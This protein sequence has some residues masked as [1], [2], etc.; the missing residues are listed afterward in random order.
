MEVF[1]DE[2]WLTNAGRVGCC[3]DGRVVDRS[4]NAQLVGARA[5][6][7]RRPV[8]PDCVAQPNQS[9]RGACKPFE[10]RY[11]T[12]AGDRLGAVLQPVALLSSAKVD[13]ALVVLFEH[14]ARARRGRPLSTKPIWT[15]G[16]AYRYALCSIRSFSSKHATSSTARAYSLTNKFGKRS[17]WHL[18]YWLGTRTDAPNRAAA[19]H[20]HLAS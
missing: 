19:C 9:A 13:L 18:R 17:G 8:S 16:Y 10:D 15:T 5:L 14:E 11:P 20:G 1:S 7:A 3:L 2:C 6:A 12:L 4:S